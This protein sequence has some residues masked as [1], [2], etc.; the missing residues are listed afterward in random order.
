[1]RCVVRNVNKLGKHK[2]N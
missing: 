2:R 1:M